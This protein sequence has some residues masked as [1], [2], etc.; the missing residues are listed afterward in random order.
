MH[1]ACPDL[2]FVEL[3]AGTEHRGVKRLVPIR[4]RLGDVVLD[5]LLHRRPPVM[6]DA[7]RVVA[8]RHGVHED[9]NREQIVDLLVGLL[10]LEHLLVNRPQML[11]PAGDLEFLD[12]GVAE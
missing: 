3:A 6:H 5:A 8:V 10:A 2:H 12:A 1:L 7:E 4:L 9:A 11:R